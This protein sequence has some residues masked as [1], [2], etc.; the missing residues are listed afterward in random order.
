MVWRRNLVPQGFVGSNPGRQKGGLW[1]KGFLF[2]SGKVPPP[3]PNFRENGRQMNSV[4]RFEP[5]VQVAATALL[6]L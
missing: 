4:K 3:A 2:V 1:S 5:K 6:A